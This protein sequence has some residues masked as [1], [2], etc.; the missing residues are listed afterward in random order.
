VLC[1]DWVVFARGLLPGAT[2]DLDTSTAKAAPVKAPE[3]APIK[4]TRRRRPAVQ[5]EAAGV[6]D[7]APAA[8]P[9]PEVVEPEVADEAPVAEVAEVAEPEVAEPAAAETEEGEES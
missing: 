5:P 6:V 4:P 2:G 3:P 1:N 7:E 9:E 8:E